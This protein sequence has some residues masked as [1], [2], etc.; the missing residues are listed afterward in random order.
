MFFYYVLLKTFFCKITKFTLKLHLFSMY[1]RLNDYK[2]A[3]PLILAI[4][5]KQNMILYSRL[6]V[7]WMLFLI[8]VNNYAQL[9]INEIV[10]ANDAVVADANGEYDDWIEI[11]NAGATAVNLA[12]YYLSD[13]IDAPT[14]WQIPATN[15]SLTTVPAGGFLLFWAD[16]EVGQGAN[17]LN[18]QLRSSGET[19]VLTAPDGTTLV[20]Q[21][22]FPTI[23]TDYGYGR[24][25]D[26]STNLSELTPASPAATNNNSQ[27]QVEKPIINLPSD[28]YSGTQTVSISAEAGATIYYTTDGSLPTTSSNTYSS[29]INVSSTQSVRAIAVK[30]GFADSFVATGTYFIDYNPSLPIFHITM[31]PDDLWDDQTGIYVT[32]TNGITGYC[33]NSTPRNWNQDWEKSAHLKVFK[34]GNLVSEN[35]IGIKIG[36]NCKRNKPQKPLNLYFRDEYSDIGDSKFTYPIFPDNDLAHFKRLFIRSGNNNIPEF[37]KDLT[38]SRMLKNRIE[39]DAQ[40]AQPVIVFL[41][42]QYIG[43]QNLREKYDRWHYENDFKNVLD[44]DS[45]DVIKNPGRYDP[46]KWWPRHRATHGDTL[47]WREFM[48]YMK[49][50]DFT[51]ESNY[52]QAQ[53]RFDKDE[54]L[55]Y[56]TAGHFFNN[57][58]WI[59]NNQKTWRA[60]SNDK[61]RWCLTDFDSALNIGQVSEN[62]LTNRMLKVYTSDNENAYETNIIY[63]RLFANEAFKAEYI[64]RMNTY[65]EVLFT[66]TNFDPTIDGHYNEIL[67]DLADAN[68]LYGHSFTNYENEIQNQKN[69]VAQRGQHVRGHMESHFGL[70]GTF[71]LSINFTANSNGTVAMHGNYFDLPYNY[72]GTYH[73]NVPVEIHAIP[74]PGY[75]FSHWQETGDTDATIYQSFNSNTTLTPVF[76]AALDVVINEIHY[77]PNDTINEKEFIEIYNPDTKARDLSA[78]EFSEGICFKFPKET[79]IGAG[80]YIVIAADATQYLGN[81]Y[82]VFQWENSKLNNDGEKLFLQNPLK[83]NIDTVRYNDGLPWALLPDGFGASLE[84]NYPP[85]ADNIQADDWHA[86]VPEGGTPGAQN[87]TPCTNPQATIVINEINYNSDENTFDPADWIE[88]Y[89]PNATPVDLSNWGFYD[90]G[91]VYTIPSGTMLE[92]DDYLILAEDITKFTTMFPHLN[93]GEVIGDFTFA[94]GNGDE[95]ISLFDANKCLVDELKY[96]D[97]MPWDSIPDGNGPTLSLIDPTMDNLLA[98]SWEASTNID[99]PNGTPG[100]ANEP[101]L[102]NTIVLPSTICAGFPA[103]VKVDKAYDGMDFTWFASGATPPNFTVD[104]TDLT[105]NNSGTYN[106]QL[107]TQYYECTKVY[108]QSVTIEDCNR[109]PNIINDDFSTNED[110]VLSNNVLAND[111]DPDNDNLTV[112]T[113]PQTNVSNGTLILNADGTFDYTPNP[114]FYGTDS[115]TYE[116]CDDATFGVPTSDSFVGQVSSGADDV[117]EI[118][119]DGSIDVGSS[120]LDLL[121][122]NPTIY[123]TVGIRITS[124]TVPQ[125]ATI[126]NAYLEF[127]ADESQSVATSLTINAEAVGNAAAIPTTNYALSSKTKT[128]AT[129]SW[130]NLPAWTTGNTYQSTDIS[131]VVQEI[132]NR[133]DWASGNAMTFLIEGTG[134]RTAESFNG[135]A[136]PKLFIDYEFLNGEQMDVSLCDVAEVTINVMPENDPPQA[137]NDNVATAEESSKTGSAISNDSDVD[138]DNLT[139]NII[140]VTPPQNG[141]VFLLAS[142]FYSYTPDTD[143]YGTDVFEYEI[144]DDGS[145]VMCDT[146]SI[147]IDVTPVN[148]APTPT[149]DTLSMFAN[150]SIQHN[151]LL[152]DS[153]IENDV[154]TATTTPVVAPSN[155]TLIIQSNGNIDYTPNPNFVGTDSFTYEVCD[156]G[157]P[158][159]C[160]TV[161][162]EIIVEPDCVDIEL[163]AWLEGAY[164]ATPGEMRTTLVTTRKLLPGQTPTSG[165]AT[166]TPAGQPYSVAPWNYAG[167]E[168]AGWTDADYTGDETDWVLVSFR[169]DIQK[170]TEVGM[171]A[172]L[173]MKDGSITFPNRCALTSTVASPLYIV[174]EHRNH[175]GVMT[176]QPVDVMDS[177]LSYDFRLSDSYRDQTSFGQKQLPTG[178]WVMFAGD[179]YQT[180]FPSFDIKGT[181]KT[182]W[183]DNN[184]IFDYYF[185]PDFN[186][187]GDIN[188]QDKSLW[189]EN[190]GISSR[191]PK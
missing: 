38:I 67:P 178:E 82:Q 138:G 122:D 41:N 28:F 72:Q 26:G 149:P 173:L 171:T 155:G 58:D 35:N 16:N 131:S 150:S 96:T 175:I 142:G 189:F 152:N 77:H 158:I 81:G 40:S 166:P 80:E 36:G 154:L 46:N 30:N 162:V 68:A 177:T 141:S 114:N 126:T 169:T 163:Y 179:A 15:A 108:T 191:V 39:L 22:S 42:E 21:V 66:N 90:S 185:S 99:S 129:V 180:D 172:G 1:L 63:H 53:N 104:S 27:P 89:N 168:G 144:C 153:D 174:I 110:N 2:L 147:T 59:P 79:S 134:T 75:R 98:P 18:F 11:Y 47:A 159:M 6:C 78:Y 12:G 8:P 94:L 50:G 23:L 73:D 145:P 37:I 167:T 56:L 24:L 146:A 143:F 107:I 62:T 61:W 70:T 33:S 17:H 102:E 25:P 5:F 124:I 34:D 112:N 97:E 52:E 133:G 183:F 29:P 117:E 187:D 60:R 48:N 160:N 121:E 105:W 92:A 84:L 132:I 32:G 69:F 136:P 51:V 127:V 165:L 157:S 188:G 170:S 113:I 128:N 95:R 111:N 181:D 106:M 148:D 45:V 116:V 91:N 186:L 109:I 86:S 103:T 10:A 65:L 71:Q 100:R 184:G 19:I 64:Q 87:S 130:A 44:K 151:V 120:D 55:N 101:C 7:V 88:L 135:T 43:I 9:Y 14:K 123:S 118:A 83:I 190:N 93:N 20:D 156:D 49:A 161:S 74:N 182:I 115:F 125:G 176:P 137:V 54:L 76:E 164:D 119:T 4:L 140:P 57:R 31:N 13:D 3:A 85:P 139:I